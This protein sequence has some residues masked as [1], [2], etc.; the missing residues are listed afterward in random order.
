MGPFVRPAFLRRPLAAGGG[1]LL[2]TLLLCGIAFLPA[3]GDDHKPGSPGT[4]IPPATGP[5]TF[6]R[7]DS[8]VLS[9]GDTTRICCGVWDPGFIDK[10]A[11]KVVIYDPSG[12]RGGWKL[13]VLADEAVADSAYSLP[14][15]PVGEFSQS[16]VNL[17]VND[18]ARGNEASSSA[19]GAR[20]TILVH[21]FSCGPPVR[22]DATIDAV[23]ASELAGG[24]EVRARGRFRAEVTPG[25]PC[26]LGY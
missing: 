14:T 5:L 10:N 17:F 9:M 12:Q 26:T 20:G 4:P 2:S 22:I 7:S 19:S 23:L 6:T 25:Y 11:L 3:C 24:S 15:A 8:T 16:P 1:D 18:V 13:F 21:S